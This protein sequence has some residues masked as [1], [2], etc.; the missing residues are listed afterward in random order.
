L[1]VFFENWR[2]D[3]GYGTGVVDGVERYSDDW[4]RRND[5]F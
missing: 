1:T 4:N 2:E 3:E 5:G